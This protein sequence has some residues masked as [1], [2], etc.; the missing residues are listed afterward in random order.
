MTSSYS[1]WPETRGEGTL[2][3]VLLNYATEYAIRKVQENQEGSDIKWDTS[4][5]D[6][7]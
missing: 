4:T 7:Y 6:I 3:Q 5:F 1:E 2:S